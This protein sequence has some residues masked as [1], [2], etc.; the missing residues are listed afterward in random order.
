[1]LFR[2]TLTSPGI[3]TFDVTNP[4]TTD[5]LSVNNVTATGGNNLA[6][7]ITNTNATATASNATVYV[8]NTNAGA[9]SITN[10][11][12][13]LTLDGTTGLITSG[14]ATLFA[15]GQ[16]NVNGDITS[17][18]ASLTG[19]G[20]SQAATSA[21]NAGAG[22]ILVEAGT[23]AASLSG[24]LTTSNTTATAI[25]VNADSG[26]TQVAGG[27]I[28]ATGAGGGVITLDG[29]AGAIAQNGSI[30]NT[31]GTAATGICITG[32][33]FTQKT[34][35]TDV[36]SIDGGA[37]GVLIEAGTGSASLSGSVTTSNTTAVRASMRM[38]FEKTSRCPRLVSCFGMK[39]SP[40]WKLARRGKSAKLVLAASTRMST[41]PACSAA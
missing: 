40:A 39:L 1:M 27:T 3:T 6:L 24:S 37:S 21:V 5:N 18:G 30:T 10:N 12:G 11:V 36:G 15:S 33:G 22:T 4:T 2:S 17:T 20:L 32:T 28:S 41:V 14:A 19:T 31:L 26:I 23:G 16:L 13:I 25:Q 9:A 7:S 34:L 38:P 35:V 29:G 8:V